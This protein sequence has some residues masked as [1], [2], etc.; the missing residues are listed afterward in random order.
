MSI[1][2]KPILM[3]ASLNQGQGKMAPGD[4][5][6]QDELLG[7]DLKLAEQILP[8]GLRCRNFIRPCEGVAWKT[9]AVQT[10]DFRL[11]TSELP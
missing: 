10:S 7:R 11:Q 4:R 6:K 3:V 2:T 9:L 1:S 8:L 5:V